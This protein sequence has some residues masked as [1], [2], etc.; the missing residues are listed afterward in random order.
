MNCKRIAVLGSTGNIGTQTVDV[1]ART[2]RLRPCVIAG[3]TNRSLLAEQAQIEGVEFVAVPEDSPEL[4][5][6]LPPGVA[7]LSGEGSLAEAVRRARPDMVVCAVVG[8]AGLRSSLAAVELGITLATANKESLVCGGGIIMPAARRTGATV[9]PIDSEHSGIF[10]CL[11]SGTTE[12]IHRVYITSSGGALRDFDD[13]RAGSATVDEV[14]NHPTWNMGRKV[15]VDSATLMNKALEIIEAH[16]LFGLP[17]DKIAVLVHEQSIVHAI[18]EFRDGSQVAQLGRPD[19]RLPIAY[20]LNY[21]DRPETPPARLDLASAAR[22]DFRPPAGR[23][24]KPL[25]LAAEVVN[26][27]GG[28]GAVLSAANEVAVRAFLEGKVR[29]GDIVPVIAAALEEWYA[30][31]NAQASFAD[32][33]MTIESV[34]SADEWGRNTACRLLEQREP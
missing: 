31:E 15:T 21:P 22:L 1:I 3:R 6:A 33:E 7:L 19:M 26:R 4:R 24:L 32:G 8:A 23:E 11:P 13:R 29:F 16:W 20:A 17:A 25:A 34:L 10:Q 5:G 9:L 27:G 14:L 2:G 30:G 28:G 18:V 12:D